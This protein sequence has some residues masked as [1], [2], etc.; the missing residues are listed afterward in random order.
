MRDTVERVLA[1]LIAHLDVDF[2]HLR[3][4]DREWKATVLVAEWPRR[5]APDPDPLS[6]VYFDQAYSPFHAVENV[7]EPMITCADSYFGQQVTSAVVPLMRDGESIG[8]LSFVKHGD[9]VWSQQ[10]VGVLRVIA[11]LLVELQRRVDAETRAEYL[12]THDKL[13]GLPNEHALLDFMGRRLRSSRPGPVAVLCVSLDGLKLINHHRGRQAGDQVLCNAAGRLEEQLED[14]D[15]VARIGGDQFV[16]VPKKAMDPYTAELLACRIQQVLTGRTILDDGTTSCGVSVG[17]AVGV[18]GE[19][20]ADVLRQADLALRAAKTQDGNGVAVYTDTICM[21]F[22]LEDDIA[23]NLRSA[24]SDDSLVLHYQ[25]EVDL[26]TGRVLAV[27][28]LV[29]WQHP[30]RGLLLPDTFIGVAEASNLADELGDWVIRAACAQLSDWHRRGL[31]SD[32]VLRINT[33]PMQLINP[34]FVDRVARALQ[35]HGIA[36]DS[37]CLEITENVAVQDLNRTD[38]TLRALK[39]LGVQIALDDFGT[40][41]NTL[42]HLQAL[43]VDIVKIDR[44]FVKYLDD[45]PHNRAIVE[46]IITLAR[47]F[48][49]AV[50]GEGVETTAAAHTLLTLGCHRAQGFLIAR[51][52]P[53]EEVE[54]HLNT[55]RIRLDLDEPP[56]LGRP[57]AHRYR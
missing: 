29:R 2:A 20:A 43:P 28:A 21:R 4:I 34:N 1:D 5:S 42:T 36:G 40:G 35:L 23:L 57:R 17:V 30:T 18:L 39:S 44:S 3:R 10:E 15:M 32:V 37:V 9:W 47:D 27:E 16:I 38:L 56:M 54:T 13:T 31:A 14:D 51:P 55:M 52:L 25:P 45:N 41:Y 46:S 6:V 53:A 12:S 7:S 22:E 8:V 50:V 19:D 26:R 11:S 24:V 33:S 49:L 48:E